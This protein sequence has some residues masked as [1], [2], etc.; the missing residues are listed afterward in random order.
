VALVDL[1][2]SRLPGVGPRTERLLQRLNVRT[3][4]EMRMLSRDSLRAMLGMPGL[5]LYERCRGEDTL[6]VSRREIPRSI[7]RE[8]SFHQDTIDRTTIEGTLHYLTERAA[9]TMRRLGLQAR[10]AGVKVRYGDGIEESATRK[11]PSP[12]EIDS[13][14]FD[15]AMKV[16]KAIHTRRAALHLVGVVLT[17]FVADNGFRQLEI[18]GTAAA[19]SRRERGLLESLDAIRER[20]GH[21]SVVCGRSLD[22]L[23]KL[24]QDDHGFILRT[25]SLTK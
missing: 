2:V 21:A 14:I 6:P 24:A 17:G 23:G 22:L 9:N 12:T 1:P 7:Q 5:V 19:S 15:F 25:S 18:I 8:T 13:E 11:L 16:L 10:Q 20:Y 3:I 4:G